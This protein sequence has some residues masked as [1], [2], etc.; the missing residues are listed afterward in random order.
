MRRIVSIPILP[1]LLLFT[2]CADQATAPEIEIEPAAAFKKPPK[3]PPPPD[4]A[5]VFISIETSVHPLAGAFTCAVED[6][7]GNGVGP[8][9][10]WGVNDHVSLGLGGRKSRPKTEPTSPVAGGDLLFSEVHLGNQF[11]CAIEDP[12]ADGSGPVYC[13]GWNEYG[14]L[15]AEVT[16]DQSS[17]VPIE[18]D[19]EFFALDVGTMGACALAG[20]GSGSGP[21][22]C[23]PDPAGGGS[24]PAR[25][26]SGLVFQ[27][28]ATDASTTCG[29]EAGGAAWCWGNNDYGQIGDG[30]E[31]DY[32]L[33][34]RMVS[35]GHSFQALAINYPISCG[36][37]VGGEV[38]CW[39]GRS[40][41]GE[42]IWQSLVPEFIDPGAGASD[43]PFTELSPGFCVIG[44][45][46]Q[47]YCWGNN[48]FGQIGDGTASGSPL[49]WVETPTRVG[50]PGQFS[51]ISDKKFHTCGIGADGF[52]YC[53]GA[54]DTGELGNGTKTDSPFP[55]L[56]SKQ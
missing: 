19:E 52:A 36:L 21:M 6:A 18:S 30:T 49:E 23:W 3:P 20:D 4:D 39:G 43:R 5:L 31:G 54:N 16:G 14:Q 45:S 47:A 56:V 48:R 8:V 24:V 17:P 10:C 32:S 25:V 50:F 38:L 22:Y 55:V 11:A 46:G 9:Y 28:L 27:S 51:Q 53:W 15:G 12:D 42:M 34:P 1:L 7:D 29:I 2:G 26:A 35:G 40:L 37:T 33:T 41:Y 44:D 13:W